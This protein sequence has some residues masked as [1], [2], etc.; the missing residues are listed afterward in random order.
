MNAIIINSSL[1]ICL[2]VICFVLFYI[3]NV[4]KPNNL[5]IISVKK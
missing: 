1:S 4:T 5:Y 3:N 2:N